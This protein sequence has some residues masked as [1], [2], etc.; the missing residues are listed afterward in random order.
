MANLVLLTFLS[1]RHTPLAPLCGKSYEKIRPL[2]KTSGYTC[3]TTSILHGVV[4]LSSW[5]Q[6][7][8][9][10]KMAETKNFAGPIAGL[11]MIT[12]GLSTATWIMRRYYEGKPILSIYA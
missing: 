10:P 9:I 8:N 7:G 12:V 5:A 3:I 6:D 11:A 1:L 2:H 4:Y